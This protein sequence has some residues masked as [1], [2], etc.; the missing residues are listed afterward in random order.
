MWWAAATITTV[1]YGD[2]VPVTGPG[3]LVGVGLMFVGIAC[4]AI[5]DLLRALDR[6]LAD[7]E[8]TLRTPLDAGDSRPDPASRPGAH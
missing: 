7:V 5:L 4:V 1:G 6:R 8:R 2:V 3:R